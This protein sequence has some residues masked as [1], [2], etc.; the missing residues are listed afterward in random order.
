MA[1]VSAPLDPAQL[2]RAEA[3]ALEDLA[4]R[5]DLPGGPMLP[6]FHAA[7]DLL[8]TTANHNHRVITTGIG[9]SG[10][11]AA[12]LAATLRSTG[13]PAHFLQPSEALHGD[14]GMITPGDTVV[15]LSA[16]GD[17]PEL[18]ALL[19]AIARIPAPVVALCGC[20]TSP[21]AQQARIFLDASVS[22]EACPHN[23]APTASTTVMLALSDALALSVSQRR[24]FAPEDFADRHPGGRLGKRLAR[25]RDRMHTGDAIP[26]VAPDCPLPELIHEMSRKKLGI[27]LVLDGPRL[28]G[29]ISDGDLRR[30]LERD[31]AQALARRARDIL[32]PDPATISPDRFASEALSLLHDRKITSLIVASP[33]GEP[34]GV[35]HLHDL[36]DL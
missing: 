12:K 2:I 34:V 35:L 9:K 18:L 32:H 11:I 5:L 24:G 27:T 22:A 15:L 36:W 6:A 3:A 19:P 25:V 13:T 10:I 16:S 1:D 33:S 14:L 17:T 26:A 23:L 21:M 4:R 30:L 31:G 20:A 29:I 28:L 8:V 7:V